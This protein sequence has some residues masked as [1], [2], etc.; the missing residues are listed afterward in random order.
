M[1]RYDDVLWRGDQLAPLEP[2]LRPWPIKQALV[3][4]GNWEAVSAA[5]Q[6]NTGIC[7]AGRYAV[8]LVPS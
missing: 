2:C 8:D 6:C 3:L 5:V 4:A 7:S 1:F